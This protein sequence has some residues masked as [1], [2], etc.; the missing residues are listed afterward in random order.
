MDSSNATPRKSQ[1]STKRSSRFHH[2]VLESDGHVSRSPKNVAHLDA[3]CCPIDPDA[4]TLRNVSRAVRHCLVRQ[5][6]VAPIS[7]N[8]EKPSVVEPAVDLVHVVKR[9]DVD[10]RPVRLALGAGILRMEARDHRAVVIERQ[11]FQQPAHVQLSI[12][13]ADALMAADCIDEL[14]NSFAVARPL[15]RSSRLAKSIHMP[16]VARGTAICPCAPIIIDSNVVPLRSIPKMKVGANPTARIERFDTDIHSC[17][18]LE[19]SCAH[20]PIWIISGRGL[21]GAFDQS[22]ITLR[23]SIGR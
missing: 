4:G 9:G 14:H 10:I 11:V 23:A 5:C 22:A 13:Q 7:H 2:E 20:E 8:V 6:D 18:H 1:N 3:G 19:L 17:S 21:A 15:K 16:V 12:P